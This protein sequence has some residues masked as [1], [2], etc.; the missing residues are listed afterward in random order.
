M[1]AQ[2]EAEYEDTERYLRKEQAY[3]IELRQSI[4]RLQALQRRKPEDNCNLRQPQD[5][6]QTSN[7]EISED[8]HSVFGQMRTMM[9]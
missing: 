5:N 8:E 7:E 9:A 4:E 1:N 2:A 6:N 3:E